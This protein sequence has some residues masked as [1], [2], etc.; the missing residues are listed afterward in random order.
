MKVCINN[1]TL[2]FKR[3]FGKNILTAVHFTHLKTLHGSS[4]KKNVHTIFV[5]R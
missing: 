3:N 4:K 1:L 5:N 2:V